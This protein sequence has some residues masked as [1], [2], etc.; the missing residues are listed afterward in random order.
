G[1]NRLFI[2]EQGGY[3]RICDSAGLRKTTPF[4]DIHT[5]L[6]SGGERGL[7][8][9]TFDLNYRDNGYFYVYYTESSHGDVRI[10]RFSV[11]PTNPDSALPNSESILITIYHP[12]TNH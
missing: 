7:L 10:S 9:L 12:Y 2:V 3:I 5:R 4:L 1:D 8:G 11:S 6:V